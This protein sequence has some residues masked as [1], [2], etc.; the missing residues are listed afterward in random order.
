MKFFLTA[1]LLLVTAP[2]FA[3]E[4]PIPSLPP[5]VVLQAP[6]LSF[7]PRK[8]P[9]PGSEQALRHQIEAIAAGQPDYDAMTPSTAGQ[10]R[11]QFAGIAPAPALQW[12]ALL[13]LEFQR[14]TAQT[15]VYEARFQK[16][17]V[18]WVIALNRQ[19]K[20]TGIAFKTLS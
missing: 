17:R 18:R 3:E 13:S 15:D 14:Y 8:T 4:A 20:I 10:L 2:A 5:D 11:N 7:I 12:G 6:Q 16:A 9:H 19:G 1:A